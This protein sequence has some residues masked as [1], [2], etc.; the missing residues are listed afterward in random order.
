MHELLRGYCSLS[1]MH[2]IRIFITIDMKWMS[3]YHRDQIHHS[4]C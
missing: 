2:S 1:M 4:F 3:K